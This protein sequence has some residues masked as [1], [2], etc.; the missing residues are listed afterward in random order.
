MN[1][2][3][4]SQSVTGTQTSKND[5]T[6]L[7]SILW[8]HKFSL[9]IFTIL[10][11]IVG[12]TFAFWTRPQFNSDIL[13]QIDPKGNKA[14]KA[15]GE[16]G[17]LLETTSPA[18]AEIK[19]IK[20]RMILA[21]VV[22]KEHLTFLATPTSPMN[23]LLH[24]EGRMDLEELEIP[25]T[26][27][28]EKW[29]AQATG[30]NTFD[31]YTP[32]GAKLVSGNVGDFVSAPFAGDTLKIQ[33]KRMIATEGEE[34]SLLQTSALTAIRN[35]KN[36]LNVK[37]D[38][39]QT[40][41]IVVN[42]SHRY[43]DRAA[44][45]LN[46]IANTYL[47][48][49]VEMRSAEAEKTLAFLEEQLPSIK[50]KLDSTEKILANYRH[51]IGS[52]DMVG[53]TQAHLEKEMDIQRQLLSL[54]QQRQEAVRLFKD[55]HPTVKTIENQQSR[56]R[57]ALAGLKQKAETMP[58]KQQEVLRL[59]EE[60]E[61][62][63]M[64][65]TSMLN[66]IQQLRVVRAGEVGN[67][68]IVDYAQIES[69][70]SE[71]KMFSI[72]FTFVA[73][74]FGVGVLLIFLRRRMRNGVCSSL[75]LERETNISVFA[76]IPETSKSSRRSNK[77]GLHSIVELDPDAPASEMFRCLHTAI[78]FSL[79]KGQKVIMVCGLFTGVG[80]SFISKN[81]TDVFALNG[82]KVVLVDADIRRGVQGHHK[83]MGLSEILTNK[84]SWQDVIFEQG[85]KGASIIASGNN[86]VSPTE[87]LR[88]EQFRNLIDNLKNEF[89][90]VIIDT[91]PLNLVADAMLVYPLCDFSLIVIHYGRHSMDD[92]KEAVA[93]L[94]RYG[95]KPC[96]FVMNRCEYESNGHYGYGYKYK[97]GYYRR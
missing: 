43:A 44:D 69:I 85:C 81:L 14:S 32:Q 78:D 84:A 90:I 21:N 93:N 46:S 22:E 72:L 27:R 39:K 5:N 50:A 89:D 38:G 80:K 94:K 48:Q 49:N 79:E 62:N 54:E 52:V 33:V 59:Q 11:A 86:F 6:S 18:E 55:E 28:N 10:G 73:V 58:L 64:Q 82:K 15:M 7:F 34:F 63:N 88:H 57:S 12:L 87:L 65:Y 53:E 61:V 95:E 75:E 13:L 66:N 35:L 51:K 96:A 30:P 60:V 16:M 25:E 37:E 4:N 56:L 67:V 40:G 47:R 26:A 3:N 76:K 42:Y 45:I 91:P 97:R 31:I 2:N 24:K 70:P 8:H 17:A 74:G 20:S 41:I 19:L 1:M 29:I 83:Q 71:P 36:K 68:R 9:A 77:P 23:R 92:I